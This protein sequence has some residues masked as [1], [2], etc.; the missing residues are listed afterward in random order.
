MDTGSKIEY[1]ITEKHVSAK[2]IAKA[3]SVS[4]VT[5]RKR[6]YDG[7]FDERDLVMLNRAYGGLLDE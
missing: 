6:R 4:T 7:A 2:G 5:L 1:L 3:L